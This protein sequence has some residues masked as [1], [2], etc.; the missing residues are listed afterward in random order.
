MIEE[1]RKAY[2]ERKKDA[3]KYDYGLVIVIGGS[4]IYTGS[5]VLS[6]MAALRSGADLSHIIA[7]S[8]VADTAAS[9]SPDLI[10][11]PL[12][13][14]HLLPEHLPDLLALTRGGEDV[15]RGRMAVVLGGGIGREEETKKTVREYVKEVSVPVV[16]DADAV[17]AFEKEESL[18]HDRFLGEKK[19][20]LTPHMYEFYVLTGRNVKNFSK[21]ERGFA[22]KS[23]AKEIGATIL[24]KGEVDHISDGENSEENE[25][26]VPELTVGGTGDVLAGIAGSL[27]ARGHSPLQAGK[28]AV[29]VN[30]L[31]GKLA[32]EEKGESL[33]ATDVIEKICQVI[34]KGNQNSL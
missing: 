7:P 4:K 3:R 10:T 24:L 20:L 16:V 11:F 9:F 21:E 25:V 29:A 13:G 15:S 26:G 28:V 31:A 34:N 8:R 17:Y 12:K 22:V 30:T 18:V 14:D 6:A 33:L 5:P 23:A 19:V 32:A 1:I 2:P 27:L